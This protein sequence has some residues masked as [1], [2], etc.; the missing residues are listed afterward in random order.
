[1][2]TGSLDDTVWPK[3]RIVSK[4]EV[5]TAIYVCR[6]KA[7][8]FTGV[9]EDLGSFTLSIKECY[10]IEYGGNNFVQNVSHFVPNHTGSHGAA[11]AQSV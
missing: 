3:R 11:I 6:N 8:E 5:V 1:V 9:S 2:L 4:S 7:W 10:Y